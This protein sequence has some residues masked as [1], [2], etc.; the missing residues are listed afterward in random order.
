MTR[1]VRR[2]T[3]LV[4]VLFGLLFVNLNVVQVLRA[5]EFANH[6]SNRRLLIQEYEIRRGPIIAG[7]QSIAFSRETDHELKYLRRYEPAHRYAHLLGYYSVVYARAGLEAALNETLTGNPS[8]VLAQNLLQLLGRRDRPGNAVRL[9]VD[10]ATQRAAQ[11]ALEGRVGAVVALDPTTGAVLAHVS[12]PSYDPNRLSSHEPADIRDYWAA[13]QEDPREPLADRAT[14]RRYQPGST[15]KLIVAAAALE[16]GIAPDTAFEDRA[17]YTPPNTTRAIRNYGGGTCDGGGTITFERALVVSCN[18]V[19]AELGVRLGADAI[20]D[21]AQRFGFNRE[22][23]YELDVAPSVIPKELDAPSTAQSAIGARDV[24]ATAMQMAM[25]AGAISNNGVLMRPHVVSEVLDP[26]GRQI[27]GPDAGPWIDGS[28]T[29]EAMNPDTARTLS[30]FMLE[31]V[32]RGTATRAQISG[33]TVGGKTG[34]ADP[35]GDSP[36]HVWF[37]GFAGPGDDDPRVAVAVVLPS[38]G[39]GTTGGRDAAPIARAVMEAA[40]G[41]R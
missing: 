39:E 24:Q 26:S 32:Q 33:A 16:H 22:L 17:A 2:V 21:Q 25:V 14:A 20:I 6:P 31:T 34:T 11:E 35:G 19:F 3:A 12:N 38:A 40:L 15:F 5:A 1:Q 10:P 30:R 28:F 18:V 27:R 4:L 37:A 29:A 13:L 7:D 9:T 8:D 23:P 36:P 41:S